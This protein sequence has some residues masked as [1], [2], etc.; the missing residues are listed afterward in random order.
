[1]GVWD[2]ENDFLRAPLANPYD[3][4]NGRFGL[5]LC[6]VF[7]TLGLDVATMTKRALGMTIGEALNNNFI[8]V[9]QSLMGDPTLRMFNVLPPTALTITAN[10]STVGLSWTPSTDANVVGYNIYCAPTE[11]GPY[12]NVSSC[13][14]VTSYA[15]TR[16]AAGSLGYVPD[17]FYTVRAV[18][19]ETTGAGTYS[20]MSDG[21]KVKVPGASVPYLA[22]LSQPANQYPTVDTGG[23]IANSVAFSVDA[24][25]CD[26]AGDD[27]LTYQWFKGSAPIP[28]YDSHV[29][30]SNTRSIL[31]KGIQTSDAGT[32]SVRVSNNSALVPNSAYSIMS[33]PAVLTLN[34]SSPDANPH[35]YTVY[36]DT[37]IDMNVITDAGDT[38]G[39]GVPLKIISVSRTLGSSGWNHEHKR[40][41]DNPFYSDA[42]SVPEAVAFTYTISDVANKAQ[43]TVTMSVNI[44]Q[45]NQPPTIT[46]IVPNQQF[47]IT[48]GEGL[49]VPF[50]VNDDRT[51]PENLIQ[52]LTWSNPGLVCEISGSGANRIL[53]LSGVL[54]EAGTSVTLEYT[55]EDLP[56]H[57]LTSLWP[58]R[59]SICQH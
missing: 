22:I 34:P 20:N 43:A 21:V 41:S 7:D 57:L 12:T 38:S 23:G 45:G 56:V 48:Q 47:T 18:K 42:G 52:S 30:G 51:T 10:A 40:K 36:E 6:T 55:D 16:T 26:S 5:G 1:M 8:S 49:E 15:A 13:G 2:T 4:Q 33:A 28:Y 32:Y 46:G 14:L 58:F 50:T 19:T 25:G 59:V 31:I 24:V 39:T 44:P 54:P 37:P 3:P 53:S 35:S 27:Q 9:N 29:T 11:S 17:T